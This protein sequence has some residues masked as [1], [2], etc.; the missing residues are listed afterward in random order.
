[1]QRYLIRSRTTTLW[2]ER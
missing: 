1:M 2:C